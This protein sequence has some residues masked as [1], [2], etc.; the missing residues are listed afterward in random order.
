M[1]Y[2]TSHVKYSIVAENFSPLKIHN[3]GGKWSK[4]EKSRYKNVWDF[5]LC[6]L[7]FGWVSLMGWSSAEK[8]LRPESGEGRLFSR[9]SA[10]AAGFFTF[11]QCHVF[12]HLVNFAQSYTFDVTQYWSDS[13]TWKVLQN[14]PIHW[15]SKQT[16]DK[17]SLRIMRDFHVDCTLE[18]SQ[19]RLQCTE[20]LVERGHRRRGTDRRR[21]LGL[22]LLE[23]RLLFGNSVLQ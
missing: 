14:L 13:V 23:L 4:S 12:F 19:L 1:G 8:I 20:L 5:F 10:A 17:N 2:I 21:I 15:F 3:S 6:F 16:T 9:C 22:Q 18:F 7:W 11:W